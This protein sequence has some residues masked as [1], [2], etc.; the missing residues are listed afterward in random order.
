MNLTNLNNFCHKIRV[1]DVVWRTHK[2]NKEGDDITHNRILKH[3]E[4]MPD[5]RQNKK[6]TNIKHLSDN[7]V[8]VE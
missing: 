4:W 2:H 1:W 3:W 6:R 5:K 7:T 8:S